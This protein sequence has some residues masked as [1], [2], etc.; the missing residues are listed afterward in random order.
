M[1]APSESLLIAT[2]TALGAAR[3]DVGQAVQTSAA[4]PTRRK[5]RCLTQI[6]LSAAG[7]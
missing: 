2:L 4:S 7:V 1:S 5:I 6:L 3:I